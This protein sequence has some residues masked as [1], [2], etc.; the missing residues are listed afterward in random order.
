MI[1]G[2]SNVSPP[3]PGARCLEAKGPRVVVEC[4]R[5][6]CIGVR[7]DSDLCVA[8][9]A[10]GVSRVRGSFY[11][12]ET[13]GS[14]FGGFLSS[15]LGLSFGGFLRGLARGSFSFVFCFR[16]FVRSFGSAF[17]FA[18]FA[19]SC[20]FL[21]SFFFLSLFYFGFRRSVYD[22]EFC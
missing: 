8:G 22:L 16:G 3:F 7:R 2:P 11:L 1:T 9:L 4:D 13:Y 20:K 18:L 5:H 21:I 12:K 14:P 15:L 10:T 6:V 17:F 19:I